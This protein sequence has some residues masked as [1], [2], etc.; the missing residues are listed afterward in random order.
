MLPASLCYNTELIR[1]FVLICQV[2]QGGRDAE[3]Q[4]SEGARERRGALNKYLF[5]LHALCVPQQQCHT[6]TVLASLCLLIGGV[7]SL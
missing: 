6:R 3:E 1:K 4:G 7:C 2:G 5:D